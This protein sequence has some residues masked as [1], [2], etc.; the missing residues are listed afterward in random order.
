MSLMAQPSP[1]A[2]SAA[3]AVPLGR[4]VGGQER[5]PGLRRWFGT[6]DPVRGYDRDMRNDL[7]SGGARL[8]RVGG[9]ME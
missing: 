7:V 6:G 3:R 8:F 4:W 1:S 9:G 5:P 2:I